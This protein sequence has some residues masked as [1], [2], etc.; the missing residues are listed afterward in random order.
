MRSYLLLFIVFHGL[1]ITVSAQKKPH[2]KATQAVVKQGICGVVRVKRGNYM[3]S[4]DSP[5]QNP[6]GTP[7]EREVLIFPLLNRSQVEAGEHGFINSVGDVKPVKV[8]RSRNDGTFCVSLPVGRYTVMVQEEKGLYANLSDSR[9]NLF[10]VNVQKNKSIT[11]TIDI[12]HQA[13]F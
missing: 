6:S 12:T 5:Q 10:P 4:P 3:P 7:V 1:F 11:V 8:V 9:N 2:R 13:V